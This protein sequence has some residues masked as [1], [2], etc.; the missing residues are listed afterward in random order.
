MLLLLL[1]L[2]AAEL[3]HLEGRM[4]MPGI[5]ETKVLQMVLEGVEVWRD[6]NY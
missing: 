6:P 2:L 5:G 4:V 1:P 3:A